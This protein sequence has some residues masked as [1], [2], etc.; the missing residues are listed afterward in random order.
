MNMRLIGAR[1]LNEIVPEM[2]DASALHSRVGLSPPDNLYLNTCGSYCLLISGRSLT[3]PFQINL[4]QRHSLRTSY[5]EDR[6]GHT[7]LYHRL[8]LKHILCIAFP[9]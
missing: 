6:L 2:V 9:S 4:S 7:S 8:Y 3:S 1:N 5:N